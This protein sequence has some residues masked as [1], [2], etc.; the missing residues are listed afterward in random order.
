MLYEMNEI[1]SEFWLGC[2]P[3]SSKEYSMRPYNIYHSD[4]FNVV[5]T[6][7]GRTALEYIVEFLKAQGKRI[8]YL[9]SYCCHT[10]IEP[11]IS[12]GM[13]VKF[14]DVAYTPYGLHRLVRNDEVYDAILL[15]DYFGKVDKETLELAS[16]ARQNRKIVIYDATHSMYSDVE[17]SHYDFIYGSYRKW[18]NINCGFLAWKKGGESVDFTQVGSNEHYVDLRKK[19]FDIKAKYIDGEL[20]NKESFLPLIIESE[21]V[22][23]KEYHHCMPDDWSNEVLRTT[24]AEY[25]KNRR[26]ANAQILMSALQDIADCRIRCV[27]AILG[28]N[29]IPL[30]VPVMIKA[31]HRDALRCYLISQDIYCP[32]HWP[33]TAQHDEMTGSNQLFASELS[34]ICDQRYDNSDMMRIADCIREYWN[35]N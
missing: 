19:L 13:E 30:F 3:S 18:V 8:A 10:M 29:D 16:F 23:E 6:L 15:M 24:D 11:F 32:V 31:I 35:K 9:P 28:L 1:G 27:N 7:S 14:Y 20:T 21:N 4:L 33:L 25:L 34:L 26:R 17:Y 5:E 22:L 12:H 2:T